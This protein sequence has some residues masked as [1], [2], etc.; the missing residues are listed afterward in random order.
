M[1]IAVSDLAFTITPTRRLTSST[2]IREPPGCLGRMNVLSPLR[3]RLIP[4]LE[5]LPVRVHESS[6]HDFPSV[7]FDAS[8]CGLSELFSLQWIFEQ[9]RDVPREGDRFSRLIVQNSFSEEGSKC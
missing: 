9:A 7:R 6:G 8:P 5:A 1:N 3:R 4:A 2:H